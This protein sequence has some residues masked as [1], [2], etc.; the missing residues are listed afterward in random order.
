MSNIDKIVYHNVFYN[1]LKWLMQYYFH[2]QGSQL[3]LFLSFTNHNMHPKS[4][5][6]FC[7]TKFVVSLQLLLQ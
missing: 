2:M 7:V 3:L 1:L 6:I 5:K 4:Y